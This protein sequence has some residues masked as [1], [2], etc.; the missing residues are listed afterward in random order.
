[1]TCLRTITF[2]LLATGALLGASAPEASALDLPAIGDT[3]TLAENPFANSQPVPDAELAKMRG[4]YVFGELTID[5]GLLSSTFVDGTLVNETS[6]NSS[7]AQ[8]VLADGI[9][10]IVQ[11]GGGNAVVDSGLLNKIPGLVTVIQNNLNDTVIQQV[12]TLDLQVVGLT[13]F[14]LQVLTPLIDFQNT[15]ALGN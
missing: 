11:V 14:E 8:K 6:I 9:K 7:E 13:E 15:S 10:T 1:M 12:D 4:G 5:F 2:S 3:C